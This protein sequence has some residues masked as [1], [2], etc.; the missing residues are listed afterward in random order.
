MIGL[1][2]QTVAGFSELLNQLEAL[3]FFAYVLPFLLMFAFSYAIL[4]AIP[5][6]RNNK[7]AA[8]IVA[9][10]ISLL[11]LQFNF[12]SAFFQNIFPN[13]GIGLSILLIGL[14]L[15]GAFISDETAYKWIFFGLGSLIFLIVVFTSFSSW[16]FLGSNWWN[17]YGT[18]I[19]VIIVVIGAVVGVVLG[20]RPSDEKK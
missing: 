13:F 20:K 1:M 17:Q 10:A 16:Q 14:I 3:G 2:L 4:T 12:V 8:L 15:A 19:I 9:I 11:A 18:L 6:F 5:V 7:G